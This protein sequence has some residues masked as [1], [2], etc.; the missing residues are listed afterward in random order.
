M[1]KFYLIAVILGTIYITI[2]SGCAV[3]TKNVNQEMEKSKKAPVLDKFSAKDKTIEPPIEKIIPGQKL[4]SFFVEEKLTIENNIDKN[5]ESNIDDIN[6][7]QTQ[8]ATPSKEQLNPFFNPNHNDNAKKNTNK[9]FIQSEIL[10]DVYFSFDQYNI[11][12]SAKRILSKNAEWLKYNPSL[13]VQ[14]AG[15]C[16]ERGTNNYN[17]ALGDRRALYVKK[18][19][20]FL[21]ISENR[22]FPISYG[23]EKPTCSKGEEKCWS[24]NRRVQFLIISDQ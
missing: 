8:K 7:M 15:H 23:E 5:S 6:L 13:K 24:K 2:V 12:E 18:Q 22:M 19:L 16:D 3:K 4:P 14:L 9:K 10:D 17:I 1:N 21:G 20:A 11:D